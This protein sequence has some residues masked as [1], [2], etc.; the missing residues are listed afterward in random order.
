MRNIFIITLLVSLLF[1]PVWSETLTMDDLVERNNL[2]YKKFTDV[3]FNGEVSGVV[4]GKFK[5][6]KKE[7]EWI[8][9]YKTGQLQFKKNFKNGL[10]DGPYEFYYENGQLDL[11]GSFKDGKRE[12]LWESYYGNRQLGFRGNYKNS[13]RVG[14]WEYFGEDGSVWTWMTGTYKNGIK[15][16]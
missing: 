3:P 16:E 5:K 11:K 10:L 15:Q 9:Y 7:G 13:I 14:F 12:G 1:S 6:G 2:Y 8:F 4:E